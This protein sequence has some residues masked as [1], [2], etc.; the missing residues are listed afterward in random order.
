[1]FH[2]HLSTTHLTWSGLRSNPGL[3]GE[4][5]VTNSLGHG[6][7]SFAKVYP[8]HNM[9]SYGKVENKTYHCDLDLTGRTVK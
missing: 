2:Y 6:T 8:F 9:K 1:M 5:P 3:C 4:M 7:V